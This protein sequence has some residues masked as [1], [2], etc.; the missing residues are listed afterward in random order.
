MTNNQRTPGAKDVP[1][2]YSTKTPGF[3]IVLIDQS[4]SMES[5]WGSSEL[6]RKDGAA[7]YVNEMLDRIVRDSQLEKTMRPRIWVAVCGYAFRSDGAANA[8]RV[9]EEGWPADLGLT[10]EWITPEADGGTPMSYAFAGARQYLEKY[11][12]NPSRAQK[13]ANSPPPIIVN[14]TD[15]EANEFENGQWEDLSAEVARIWDMNTPQGLQPLVFHVHISNAY[16]GAVGPRLSLAFPSSADH[17]DE[18]GK[19][20]FKISSLL[21]DSWVRRLN[22]ELEQPV[23]DGAV[24]LIT[25][26]GPKDLMKILTVASRGT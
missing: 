11:F 21:P 20:L 22:R 7:K 19:Q 6:L 16:A 14:V 26:A 2:Q 18:F 12:S 13:F 4:G 17:L 10:T 24:G 5:P 9:L 25:N 8:F 15:G 3:L 1:F 23:E